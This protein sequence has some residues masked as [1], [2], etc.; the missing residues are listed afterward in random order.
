M[1]ET[2]NINFSQILQTGLKQRLG[3]NSYGTT[4]N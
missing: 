4:K 3:I 1:A 2:Q